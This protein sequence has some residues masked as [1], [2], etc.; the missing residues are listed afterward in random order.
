MPAF[1]EAEGIAEFLEEIVQSFPR[2]Q[3]QIVVVDDA[4]TDGTSAAV[5]RAADRGLPARAVVNELNF[6]H[7]RS[8]LRA[9]QYGLR[10]GADVIVSVDGDGQFLGE[11][12][13]AVAELARRSTTAVEGCRFNRSDPWFRG[14]VSAVTRV[15]VRTASGSSPVD[16]NT[17]LRAYPAPLLQS[18]IDRLPDNLVTPNLIISAMIRREGVDVIEIPVRSLPR[19]GTEISGSTW[20]QRVSV[21]PSLR[22]I[23]FCWRAFVQWAQLRGG[24]TVA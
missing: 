20:G 18:L 21:L 15:L 4:S 11:D 23:T 2:G 1:N 3:V 8:T 10:E 13:A 9:L 6:G 24:A 12:I 19:R 22:F 14:L 17:P 7:G 16:A 5:T